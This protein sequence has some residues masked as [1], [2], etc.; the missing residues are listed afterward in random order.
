MP[1]PQCVICA[2]RLSNEAV[3][4]SKL[5]RHLTTEHKFAVGK[6]LDYFKRILSGE[7]SQAKDFTRQKTITEKA[8]EVAAKK[9]KSHTST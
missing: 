8:K 1:I 2:E 9:M 4:P 3:V 7:A 5:K 6:L